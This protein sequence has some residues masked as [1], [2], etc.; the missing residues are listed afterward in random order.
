MED[1]PLQVLL[2]ED[3]PDDVEIARWLLKKSRLPHELHVVWDGPEALDYLFQEMPPDLILLDLHLPKKDGQ[4]VLAE[5]RKHSEFR[6]IPIVV[7][8]VSNA[9]QDIGKTLQRGVQDYLLKGQLDGKLLV[10]SV[11]D[12]VQE[13]SR[14]NGKQT[15]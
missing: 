3:N 11:R 12:V 14:A 4:Q 1:K 15:A 2:V 7:L 10:R 13:E 8:T 5:I 6:R 9:E